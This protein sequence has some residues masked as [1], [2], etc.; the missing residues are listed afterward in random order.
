ML[1]PIQKIILNDFKF[2]VEI[3]LPVF[4][5]G[6]GLGAGCLIYYLIEIQYLPNEISLG[7]GFVLFFIALVFGFF[8]LF[9]ILAEIVL[10]MMIWNSISFIFIKVTTKNIRKSLDRKFNKWLGVGKGRNRFLT[11]KVKKST[12]FFLAPLVLIPLI[13]FEFDKFGII[14]AVM[15]GLFAYLFFNII[16][17]LSKEYNF[18][19]RL[20]GHTDIEDDFSFY[21]G[22]INSINFKNIDNQNT[23]R[24]SLLVIIFLPFFYSAYHFNVP[25]KMI[26]STMNLVSM[27]K[28]KTII[29]VKKE[30]AEI[31]VGSKARTSKENYYPI[32][33]VTILFKGIGKNTYLQF[34]KNG[35]IQRLEIPN[36]AILNTVIMKED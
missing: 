10:G 8:L 13:F 4:K 9:F 16:Y 20:R 36:D 23:V 33:K 18:F 2:L 30:Y 34:S 24:F 7:D 29:Y 35:T 11:P 6:I 17:T 14:W 1:S 31:I 27:R 12:Y 32:S 3:F 19:Y 28:E 25:F 15:I 5:F 22:I 21:K 26:S